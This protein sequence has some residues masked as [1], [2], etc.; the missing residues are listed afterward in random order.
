MSVP[1]H[2]WDG[3]VAMSQIFWDL[4]EL[5]RDDFCDWCAKY[6]AFGTFE[7]PITK[8]IPHQLFQISKNLRH[9]YSTVSNMRQ[10]GHQCQTL[11]GLFNSF[12]LSSPII[13]LSSSTT[14][15]S[16]SGILI[17]VSPCQETEIAQA[18][19]WSLTHFAMKRNSNVKDTVAESENFHQWR[20]QRRLSWS[21]CRSREVTNIKGGEKKKKKKKSQCMSSLNPPKMSWCMSNSIYYFSVNCN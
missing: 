14:H 1:S 10:Y 2:I 9:G 6:L 18:R 7:T 20:R 15:L 13:C 8:T 11:F 19:H 5:M 12:F 17:A 3:T 21:N 4:E 16:L